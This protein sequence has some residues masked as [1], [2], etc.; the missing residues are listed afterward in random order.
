MGIDEY[1]DD[2]HGKKTDELINNIIEFK[3]W[4]LER[5]ERTLN[6]IN[7]LGSDDFHEYKNHKMRHHEC[8]VILEKMNQLRI[9]VDEPSLQR[10][11]VDYLNRDGK[12]GI[13]FC[14]DYNTLPEFISILKSEG[15]TDIK[16]I[17]ESYNARTIE[18]VDN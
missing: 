16:I 12:R 6:S 15:F 7:N 18:P 10:W 4:L 3:R 5:E 14:R 1:L 8:S 13:G 9:L 17:D 11:R 2:I